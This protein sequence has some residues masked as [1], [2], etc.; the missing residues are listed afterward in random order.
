MSV[1][2]LEEVGSKWKTSANGTA[3]YKMFAIFDPT[4]DDEADV[5]AAFSGAMP[6][7]YV[8][9]SYQDMDIEEIS[10]GYCR[11]VGNYVRGERQAEAG[12]N[13]SATPSEF[14]FQIE[15]QQVKIYSSLEEVA[16]ASLTDE[17]S[18]DNGLL[19]GV[20]P[21][22]TVE[23]IEIP[24]MVYSFE[25]TH[26]FASVPDAYKI[27]LAQMVG[28]VNDAAFR[29]GAEG[30]V[31]LT[32]VSGSKTGDDAW[33]IRY[34]FQVIP[35]WTNMDIGEFSGADAITKRG[36]DYIEWFTRD[37]ENITTKRIEKKITGY[38]I[39]RVFRYADYSLLGIGS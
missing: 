19:I 14:S 25:E 5:E 10:Y 13:V 7:S 21:D 4:T 1:T 24:Q 29:I 32:G 8:G 23:G 36:W 18:P 9:Y 26:N 3:Q 17:T 30:E 28:T 15:S 22:G 16:S 27:V 33:K 31:M 39:H 11:A 35:N 37:K 6:A 2:V 38:K 34:R 12:T 20:K